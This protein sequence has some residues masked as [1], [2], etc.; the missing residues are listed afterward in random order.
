[1]PA[2]DNKSN[3]NHRYLSD[4]WQISLY[5]WEL[6]H[7]CLALLLTC[8]TH[9]LWLEVGV[10]D[11]VQKA[12]PFCLANAVLHRS[13][14][15]RS[16]RESLEGGVLVLIL[17]KRYLSDACQTSTTLGN[18]RCL[19]GIWQM[20]TILTKTRCLADVCQVPDALSAGLACLF[21]SPAGRLRRDCEQPRRQVR[22]EVGD[23]PWGSSVSCAVQDYQHWQ[24]FF[25]ICHKSAYLAD[26]CQTS[27]RYLLALCE[28]SGPRRV[29]EALETAL[30]CLAG[31]FPTV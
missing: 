13:L 18:H 10:A 9:F 22:C 19:A 28:P 23:V 7:D 4:V 15:E 31:T 21:G 26:I 12:L 24:L 2:T 14:R 3:V 17:Q 16:V 27:N 25:H 5:P 30:R 6:L 8:H 20:S 11:R 1:M 29:L